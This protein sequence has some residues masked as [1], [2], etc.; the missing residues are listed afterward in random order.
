MAQTEWEKYPGNPVLQDGPSGAWD[1]VEVGGPTLLFDGTEYKMWYNGTSSGST[2]RIGLATSPDGLEWTKYEGNPV[3]DLGPSGAWDAGDVSAATILFDGVQYKMWYAG[4]DEVREHRRIGYATSSDGIAWT[5]HEGNPV[6]DIGPSGSW[7]DRRIESPCVLFE[8]G[9][10]KMWYTGVDYATDHRRIGHATSPDGLVW[11]KYVG[12][13]VI[14]VG[15]DG[16]WDDAWVLQPSVLFDGTEYQM[17]FA[18]WDGYAKMGYATSPYGAEWTKHESNP[19]MVVGP[20]GSWDDYRVTDPYVFINGTEYQMWYTAHDGSKWRIGHATA[21]DVCWDNDADGYYDGSCGGWDCDDSDPDINPGIGVY[22]GAPELCD[23]LD[24]DCDGTLPDDELDDADGDG[25]MICDGDCDDTDAAISPGAV[26]GAVDDPTCSDGIDNDCDGLTDTD[27]EC[28]AIL[29]PDEQSTIQDAI[30]AAESGNTILVAPGIY[31]EN[32]D[33][34][35]K[36]LKVHSVDGPVKTI[37]D[38]DRAGSV[39]TFA[40][41]ETAEAVLDGFTIRNGSGTFITLPYLGAGFYSGGGILCEDSTPAITNCM[42]TNNYAYLGGGI[43]IR[44]S[45]PAITNCMIV[46]NRATGLIHGGGGLYLDDSTPTI[47]HCTV[48][49]NRAGQ[50]GGGIFCWNSSPTITNSILWGDFSI[51]DPEIHVRSGSPVITYS[52]VAGGWSGEGN[53]DANPSFAGAVTFHLMPGS[54]CV[55]SGTDAGVYTDMD[56]QRRPWGVGFDMGADEFSTEPCSVIASSGGQFFALYMIPV[57]ALIL[58]RQR[59]MIKK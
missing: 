51:Y 55:D 22:P 43:Y 4:W 8:G 33:F 41:G 5:K 14:D 29:I 59:R 7:E 1:D 16:S 52:D 25:Y 56:G 18:A 27:P 32:I 21:V 13:P 58:L 6:M 20:G 39:V 40:N 35:G 12:N 3:L 47:T 23:G 36:N 49:S 53:I 9:H 34:M 38:G 31:L 26:E 2:L 19:V 15:P 45:R 44:N 24:T 28:I 17:W 48:G 57:L 54:P 30:D 46:R 37:I 50:Y 10:Y 11:S 42:I